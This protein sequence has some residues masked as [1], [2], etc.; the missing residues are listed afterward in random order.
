MGV[1]YGLNKVRFPAPVP[2]GSRVRATTTL[3]A[4]EEVAGGVQNTVAVVI[5]REGG[6]KPVCIAEWVT[7]AYGKPPPP[8]AGLGPTPRSRG[9]RPRA[10]PSQ[11]YM[12]G[13]RIAV[14]TGSQAGP[15]S[16]QHAAATL[17]RVPGQ[18]RGRHRL[19]RGPGGPDGHRGRRRAR[20]RR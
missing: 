5:E 12:G 16:H 17:R 6:D 15:P 3:T 8:D 18:G 19:R 14:F 20:R 13:M 7:R 11:G 2:V 9:V 10:W 1:N 4:V